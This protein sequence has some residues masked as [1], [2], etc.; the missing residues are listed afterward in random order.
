MPRMSRRG[1]VESL[2]AVGA[3]LSAAPAV[4]AGPED[5][6]PDRTV[7][8]SG[9]GIALSPRAYAALL[10]ELAA[11]AE[12][13]EDSYLL[14][15]EIERFEQQ[16]ATLLGKESAVF[17]PSGTLANHLA[18]RALAGARRRVIVPE[19]S[20]IY[21][22]TGDACQTLSGLTLL[23]L[24]PGAATFTRADIEAVLA[25]TASGRVATDVGAIAIESPVRRLSGQ[26]FDWAE[27][28]RVAALARDR[29]IGLHLDG[30]RL[31]I[32]SAYTGRSPA[33]FAAPF[34]TV[35]VSL[36][37]YFNCG[38]GAILAGP[39]RV[40]EGMF[41]TRRMFGGNL[42]VGWPAALVARHYMD[43]FVERLR[44]AVE[45]SEAFYRAIGAHPRV[46][47]E[48]I[49]NG[50]NLTR[51]TLKGVDPAQVVRRLAERGVRMPAPAASGVVMLGVNETWTRTTAA[52]LVTAFEQAL[53]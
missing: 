33:E 37:K 10:A 13:E 36:W 24:A 38:Q 51:L 48:R 23:P 30:A 5:L 3:A 16:W 42:A 17:M 39:R 14:G 35:Y 45:V 40:L 12:V 53:G 49:P 2:G 32:A 9:D 43:G 19:T 8:L 7:R 41:H 46:A 6:A 34:D 22:D 26:M 11:R 50:T 52:Q 18:L 21:N 44:A 28:G 29:G 27:L 47:V 20:H 31:F 4:A 1:F 15:G 25:R